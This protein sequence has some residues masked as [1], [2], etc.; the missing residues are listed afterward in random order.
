MVKLREAVEEGLSWDSGEQVI[1]GKYDVITVM[2]GTNDL[3][4][5]L[6]QMNREFM[7]LMRTLESR[8]PGTL[9][10]VCAILPRPRDHTITAQQ[11]TQHNKFRAQWCH[12]TYHK[13]VDLYSIALDK[14]GKVRGQWFADG[15]HLSL[16]GVS[17]VKDY[18][19]QQLADPV[20][21]PFIV[22]RN[23]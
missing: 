4:S 14:Q 22:W 23:L 1:W 10:A 8:A 15:L 3:R 13:F 9:L 5:T 2:V 19:R 6:E 11:I 21:K 18:F 7:S 17:R 20:V 16:Q 12:D